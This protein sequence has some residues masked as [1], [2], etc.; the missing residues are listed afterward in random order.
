MTMGRFRAVCPLVLLGCVA[1]A[2]DA[3]SDLDALHRSIDRLA[4]QVEPH[5]IANRRYIHQHP[6]L[7]NRETETAW[8]RP[9]SSRSFA[10]ASLDRSWRCAPSWM[11]CR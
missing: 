6:E 11:P 8:R 1:A 3:A 7:S 9:V 10:V 2:T 4:D 5:V